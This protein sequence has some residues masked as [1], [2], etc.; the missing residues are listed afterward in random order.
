MGNNLEQKSE[1]FRL[2]ANLNEFVFAK[3]MEQYN[4]F[5]MQHNRPLV[6]ATQARE[7]HSEFVERL[8]NYTTVTA[9]GQTT[10]Q[11]TMATA[12]S[13]VVINTFDATLYSVYGGHITKSDSD[14]KKRIYERFKDEYSKITGLA[15]T[16]EANAER[17]ATG[18]I[19]NPGYLPISPF[20]PRYANRA[21]CLDHGTKILYAPLEQVAHY[22]LKDA[23]HPDEGYTMT[24]TNEDPQAENGV[25]LSEQSLNNQGQ[26]VYREVGPLYTNDDAVGLSRLRPYITDSEYRVVSPWMNLPKDQQMSPDAMERSAG[27]L[28]HLQSQGIPYTVTK[29]KFRGQLKADISNTKISIRLTDSKKNEQ[30]LGRVYKDGHALYM[31]VPP[32]KDKP[33]Y[34]PTQNEINTLIDYAI[35]N[36]PERVNNGAK[37]GVGKYV[38]SPSTFTSRRNGGVKE[39]STYMDNRE[40]GPQLNVMMGFTHEGDSYRDNRVIT[41]KSSNNHSDAHRVFDTQDDAELFLRDAVISARDNFAKEMNLDYL[42]QEAKEHQNEEGY[43][44]IFSGDRAIAPVQQTYWE[45]LTGRSELYRPQDSVDNTEFNGLFAALGMLDEDAM[46]IADVDTVKLNNGESIYNGTPEENIKNHLNDSMDV[47]FGNYE[48]DS[49]GK[50]FNPAMVANFMDSSY[51]VYRNS[52]NLVAAMYKMEFSGEEVRGDDFQ[53]GLMKDRMLRFDDATAE[54]LVKKETPYMKSM[55]ET[56]KSSIEETCCRVNDDDILIDK[57]GVIKYRAYMSVGR[58][59]SDEQTIDGLVGQIFEPDAQG[60]VETKYAGSENKLFT[61]GYDAYIL[62]QKASAIRQDDLMER[63]RL[64]GLEQTM[65]Q[66]ISETIRYDIMSHGSKLEG[67]DGAIIGKS[68]GTTTSVNNSYLGLYGTVYQVSIEPE[69]G[70]S[71][72]DTYIRQAEETHLPKEILDARFETAKG[73]LHFSKDIA[74]N[75][76]VAAEYRHKQF[77]EEG[78]VHDLTNDNHMDAFELTGRSNMAITQNH[79]EGFTDA[80]LTGSGKNQG[81]V[82]YLAEGV[83]VASDGHLIGVADKNARAPL[84]NTSPMRYCDYIPAD[85]VQMVG[86]NYLT[87]SGVAGLEEQELSDGTKTSGVGVAQLT[88]QGFTFDD[89]AVISKDFAEKYG[90]V[91]GDKSIRP[92]KPGDKICDFAGNKSIVAKVIDR[93]MSE[94]EAFDQGVLTSVQ[95]FRANPDLDIVQAPYSAVSRFNA[96]SAKLLMENTRDLTMPDG[97][98]KNGCIGF[99]PMIITHHTA[100]EHTKQ[101]T[102]DDVQAGKGR[103]ISAQLA[104]ALSAKDAT[105]I[106]DEA[107]SGNNSAVLNYREILNVMG[108]DMDETGT[109]RKEYQPHEG[110]ERYVFKLPTK[111]VLDGFVDKAASEKNSEEN[112]TKLFKD[113]VDN[114][115]GFLEIPFP[116]TLPSGQVTQKVDSEKSAYPERTMY[117]LPVMSSHLRSGQSFEDGTSMVHDYTNQYVRIFKN[118][119]HYLQ[120]EKDGKTSE[121]TRAMEDS[122]TAYASITEDLRMRKFDTKHNIMRDDFMSHRMPHSATAVWTPDTN[123]DLGQ[124]AMNSEMMR[125]LGV[126]EGDRTMVWRDPILRD[127]GAR[128]MEVVK[129]DS[130][131]G[132]AVNPLVAIAFDGDFD[133]DSVGLWAPHTQAAIMEA[134]DKFAFENTMLDTTV[135]R[136]NGDYALMLNDGMDVVSAEV[137]DELNRKKLLDAGETITEPS[138][139]ERRMAL[140]HQ[141]NELYK[142]RVI[143]KEDRTNRATDLLRDLSDWSRDCLCNTCGTEVVS[144][145]DL[146]AHAQSLIDMVDHGAKG[147]HKKLASYFKYYGA[148]FDLDKNGHI[149]ADSMKDTGHTLAQ[150]S[151]VIDTELATAIKSHGTGIAGAVSQRMVMFARN[152]GC[153]HDKNRSPLDENALSSVLKTTYLSTQG[154]L[155]AKHD[156]VQAKRLY[157]LVQSPVRH[158]WRGHKMERCEVVDENGASRTS[159]RPVRVE[160]NGKMEYQQAT[161]DEWVEMFLDIHEH[162]DGLDLKGFINPEQVRQIANVLY[163]A[164]TGRMYDTEDL[165]TIMKVAAPMDI[166]AYRTKGAFDMTCQMASEGRNI[167]EGEYNQRFAP[168]QIRENMIAKEKG[169]PLK[170]IMMRDSMVDFDA[171]KGAK[172]IVIT[173]TASTTYTDVIRDEK[174]NPRK[175]LQMV[176]SDDTFEETVSNLDGA[177]VDTEVPLDN[178]LSKGVETKLEDTVVEKDVASEKGTQVV[179]GFDY[180]VDAVPE[181]DANDKSSELTVK[182]SGAAAKVVAATSQLDDSDNIDKYLGED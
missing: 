116:I 113:S 78:S 83:E 68:V 70:E 86:S 104:W 141:F 1:P 31:N 75:S 117:A 129:D 155:Q 53:A 168:K 51:G 118:S 22:E 121:M 144:Y 8:N 99:A 49:F 142:D 85:R 64:R 164:D 27:I 82:R 19:K 23:Q 130:L 38:G 79:S 18:V 14:S 140:E 52:D 89:G 159:W 39:R 94:D 120:A 30:F 101:Y 172:G 93:N 34:I 180:S 106:M 54:P 24:Y 60:V 151:D 65:K 36:H 74:E 182:E 137:A 28:Q 161:K 123:L 112:I 179:T 98:V 71:L 35:G 176:E 103:K 122:K 92:L 173:H 133:G 20:D 143:S 115:G 58:N 170:P 147:S 11:Y 84:M 33:T 48:P 72:K 154:I 43:V 76:T 62:P 158:I 67:R 50:R 47:L 136:E 32:R 66:N 73:L 55:F 63:V 119:I 91:S 148:E 105:A 45:V 42:I 150:T 90:V 25:R 44:P 81:I 160:K 41:I 169:E 145:K 97:S 171:N 149:V 181:A 5:C 7:L 153:N 138:L 4:E 15:I 88:L 46:D 37:S 9:D 102:D 157:E 152:L 107:F 57:N 167:F 146:Q 16:K 162:A 126:K 3:M 175:D 165:D 77:A 156:P 80:V 61:P 87:A 174:N 139:R 100:H 132:V 96:A 6:T 114:R 109:L 2:Q 59:M 131:T 17:K 125:N 166:L 12:P 134:F 124:I 13:L 135:V 69:P 26:I 108:L 56:V 163:D 177:V 29:D 178:T 40:N 127:Y 10:R 95:L 110:E 128:Y 111:E 21:T